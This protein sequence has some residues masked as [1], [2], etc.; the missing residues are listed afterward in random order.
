MRR[1]H[2]FE[3]GDQ[4]W[5]PNVVREAT[6]DFLS[7]YYR[8]WDVYLPAFKKIT[9]VLEKTNVNTVIDCCSGSSGPIEGLRHYFDTHGQEKIAITLTDKFPNKK[10][11]EQL[12]LQYDNK[13]KGCEESIDATRLPSSLKGMRTIFS[14]FHHFMPEDA[15]HILQDAVANDA[16]IG[17]FEFT[18]RKLSAIFT[19]LLSPIYLLI[20]LPFAKK[21]NWQK[22]LFTYILPITPFT[23]MWEYLVSSIRTYSLQDLKS[24]INQV[25]APHYHWEIGRMW[26][27]KAKCRVTYLIGYNTLLCNQE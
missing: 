19:I 3:F 8:L 1:I 5:C 25:N 14:S 7:V 11:F 13:I 20:L 15:L 10:L 9:E 24:L 6:T 17:I 23:H 12:T 18:E 26:S 2:L 4:S 27:K 21:L 22:F 16:P